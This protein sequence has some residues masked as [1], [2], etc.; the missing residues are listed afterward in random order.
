MSGVA[1]F[2]VAFAAQHPDAAL[3]CIAC[4]AT[5]QGR[6]LTEHLHSKHG[7]DAAPSADV[8]LT[9]HGRGRLGLPKPLTADRSSVSVGRRFIPLPAALVAG[10]LEGHKLAMPITNTIDTPTLTETVRTGAYLQIGEFV[11]AARGV[12][13]VGRSWVGAAQG[14]RRGGAHVRIDAHDFAALQYVLAAAG[15]LTPR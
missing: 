9:A 14:Q 2:V 11:V 1:G 15:L 13:G 8:S 3:P 6:N 7:I 5:P 12:H 4:A 10:R